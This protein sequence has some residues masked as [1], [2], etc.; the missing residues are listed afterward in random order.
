VLN[1]SRM[2]GWRL[3]VQVPLDRASDRAQATDVMN[4]VMA[5]LAWNS[6]GKRAFV[7]FDHVG[8]EAMFFNAYAW[9]DDRTKEPWFRGL[10][11]SELVDALEA[12]GVSVG[13]TTNLSIGTSRREAGA[14]NP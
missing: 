14:L 3:S 12:V 1:H 10:L 5:S 8:G 13:Q 7:A 6:P 11:L 4:D 9:I 2:G